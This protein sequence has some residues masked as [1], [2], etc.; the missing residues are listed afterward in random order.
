MRNAAF[1]SR[2]HLERTEINVAK[3]TFFFTL[4]VHRDKMKT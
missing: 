2:A 3:L 4:L 1:V